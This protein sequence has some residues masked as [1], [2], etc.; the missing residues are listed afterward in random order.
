MVTA[1]EQMIGRLRDLAALD[2]DKPQEGSHG[3]TG[4]YLQHLGHDISSAG[5][6]PI[7][8]IAARQ[9]SGGYQTNR[10]H[11]RRPIPRARDPMAESVGER[12]T[13]QNAISGDGWWLS[14]PPRPPEWR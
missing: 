3:L 11:D 1:R 2:M 14:S 10:Q 7:F 9:G 13:G 12:P 5:Q 6:R 4:A 8:I